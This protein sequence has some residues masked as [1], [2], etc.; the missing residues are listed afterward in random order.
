MVAVV[1]AM[2]IA[3]GAVAWYASQRGGAV[4]RGG[5]GRAAVARE[6][7]AADFAGTEACAECH[8]AEHA[9]WR[10]SHHDLAMAAA[11]EETVAGD[12]SGAS[13]PYGD[14]VSRFRRDGD[15]FLVATD[16]PD[17]EVREY[18]VRFTFGV[19]P[20]Q[21][22]LIE[23]EDGRIQP[24]SIAWDA[25][26]AEE[27][28]QRWFH[29][30]P[31]DSIRAGDP[32]HWTGWAQ[33]WN[34]TCA[35]CHS[36]FVRKGYDIDGDRFETTWREIH[37]G[38]EACHGPGARHVAWARAPSLLRRVLWRGNGVVAPL[39]DRR[40]VTWSIDPATGTA[41]RS[42]P[43][44]DD[45]E[46]VV[47]AQCHSLRSQIADG[48]VAG[49]NLHDHY[50]PAPLLP[51]FF[52]PDG[53]QR[54]EVYT[55]ASFLHSRMYA[56]GVTCSDCHDPHS[57]RLR[58][59]GNQLCGQC[60]APARF[61]TPLHHRHPAGSAGAECVACHMP[62]R[63]YM[64]VD[65]RR[66]HR[67]AVPRPDLSAE[68]GTPNACTGCHAERSDAWAAETVR[69]WLGRDAAGFQRFAE[70]FAAH[71]AGRI[72]TVAGEPVA[73]ALRDIAVD[74]S[75]P[76]VVRAGALARL[77]ARPSP[78]AVEAARVAL[79]DPDPMVRHAALAILEALDPAERV[80]LG[81]PLLEDGTRAVRIEAARVLAPVLGRAPTEAFTRA[82]REYIESLR[83]NGDRPESRVN[84]ASLL[85]HLGRTAEALDEYRAA[86]RLAPDYAPAY[87]N[88]AEAYRLAGAEELAEVTL[89]EGLAR[90]PE[91][92][93][94][95]HALGL[96]LVRSG[97]R[98]EALEEFG[99]A[100]RLAPEDARM[101]Y[102]Y[103]VALNDA[104][105][106]ADAIRMLEEARERHPYDAELVFALAAFHRDAGDFEAARRYAGLLRE[107]APDDPR[108][109]A[110]MSQLGE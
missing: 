94:L 58:A 26:P 12:F 69:A 66:D 14:V 71:D 60:H 36:T 6:V 95:R 8:A 76:A 48:Y 13:F 106:R 97:K 63:T 85:E 20:L 51:E 80:R 104:G 99:R 22:Y 86:I 61:D 90:S 75:Q 42:Q 62:A 83:Y 25:R 87:V 35:D 96:S 84:L 70:A 89:R 11:D 56:A 49:A 46:I 1:L 109:G 18:E 57:G 39:G 23:L 52:F 17:G 7:T 64:Q 44:R 33:N 34:H 107:V 82:A 32:L 43:R 105:R 92:A 15:R 59:P 47:C 68:I 31:G 50:V 81:A 5:A 78:A 9:A 65:D 54:E 103:A 67:I 27:G 108:A 93:E 2:C 3:A 16:G 45:G 41:V 72:A 37:V 21:Q 55:Y 74:A 73:A 100:A 98:E 79:A 19:E 38:C 53:Q 101:A 91:S 4:G 102:V 24:L 77:A 29:L 30:Y 110:L 10:G 40:G 88:L 28:G